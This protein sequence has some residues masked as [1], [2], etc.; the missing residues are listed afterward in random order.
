MEKH[1]THLSEGLKL[2]EESRE[3]IRA[4]LAS[5]AV[6]KEA[7]PVKKK[8]LRLCGPLLAA[9]LSASLMVSALAIELTV[10]WENFLG[11][12]PQE[13]VTAVGAC[14]VTGDYTLTLQEAIT[15]DTGT[16]FLLAL[17]R[18]DGEPI[19][20]DPQLD[21]NIYRWDVRV[22]GQ[23]PGRTM[24]VPQK[25]IRSEDGKA[26]YYCLEFQRMDTDAE[27]LAGRRISFLCDG[28]VDM[29]WSEE[30]LALTRET[31]SLAPLAQI[32]CQLDME[33]SEAFRG[34]NEPALLSLVAESSSQASIP[35]TRLGPGTAQVS[36]VL[37]SKDGCPMVAV[38]NPD[39]PIRQGQFLTVS[40]DAVALTDTRTG[41]RWDFPNSIRRG[42]ENGFYLSA[43][44]DCPLTAED[45]PYVEVTVR[46][47]TDKILS[48]QP[49]ALSF[50]AVA[51]QQREAALDRNI[52][53]CF[54]SSSCSVHVATAKVSALRLRLN[55]DHIDRWVKKKDG[56]ASTRW[57]VMYKDGSRTTLQIISLHPC[58]ETQAVGWI[59]L[60]AQNEDGDRRLI[61]PDQVTA[62]L[63]DGSEIP[64]D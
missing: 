11:Q 45:L 60:E 6:Q 15:D 40:C 62:I 32:P 52:D 42:D 17:T 2:P 20:G 54:G 41:A 29:A 18:N 63:L 1:L 3:R 16:A 28:V 49:V 23:A 64:L 56:A 58:D 37:F 31:V 43:F 46:Y 51:D 34:K 35:L 30:E 47:Q 55:I 36:A 26:V 4:Q 48:D 33:C 59:D 5:Q 7:I 38:S 12:T 14:A 8:T 24:G 19:E 10:G 53:F 39:R 50:S 27:S 13:A 44:Q 22:D 25:S 61:D 21:G 57:E 9:A